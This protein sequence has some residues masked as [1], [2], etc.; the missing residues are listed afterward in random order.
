[1]KKRNTKNSKVKV[2]QISSLTDRE[3]MELLK[4]FTKKVEQ[5]QSCYTLQGKRRKRRQKQEYRNTSLLGSSKKL[6]FIL[7]YLKDNA[8]QSTLGYFYNMT[9]AKVSQWLNFLLPVLE[10]SMKALSCMPVYQDCY[11]HA[12]HSDNY[13]F[14]D[15]TERILPRKICKQA[16]QEDYSGKQH[17]HTEKHFALCDEVGY[18]HFISAAYTGRTHD[19][20]IFDQL[21]ID[22]GTVPFLM[23]LGFLGAEQDSTEILLPFKKA[24][25]STLSKVKKQLNQAMSSAR[26]KIEHAF[27][28]IK[29][30]KIIGE[31]TRLLSYE[32]R[33]S[34]FRIATAIHNFR[35]KSRTVHIQN[36]SL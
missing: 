27:S 35:I 15:V 28:G 8:R 19:K 14:G 30:L 5:K 9:Q 31:K 24:K 2:N 17:R 26:V 12:N 36:Y 13:L 32:K 10:S 20:A 18:I 4:I 22:T 11:H 6:E 3:T 33:Q 23:D 1:V 29:R 34:I 16:Q 25:N 21:D 7:L